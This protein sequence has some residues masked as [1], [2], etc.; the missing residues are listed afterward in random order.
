MPEHD[1]PPPA[2]RKT[3]RV[4]NKFVPPP[5]D[6]TSHDDPLE[7]FPLND[8]AVPA[9]N[10][11]KPHC[12]NTALENMEIGIDLLPTEI[13][14]DYR[15]AKALAPRL[16]EH[17]TT[18]LK[19]LMR[20]DWDPWAAAT[21]ICRHW[22]FRREIFG[23]D[24]W[25][26]PLNDLSGKGAL[27]DAEIHL[28]RRG[29]VALATNNKGRQTMILNSGRLS[30]G[31]TP[32]DFSIRSR[33]FM[34]LVVV[35]STDVSR[36]EGFDV[37]LCAS[38]AGIRPSPSNARNLQVAITTSI[39]RVRH[40][41]TVHDPRDAG[42]MLVRLCFALLRRTVKRWTGTFP[43]AVSG[44]TREA[45]CSRMKQI[46]MEPDCIPEEYGG[47]WSYQQSCD[48]IE[49]QIQHDKG[50]GKGD[51]MPPPIATTTTSYAERSALQLPT[52][53]TA[54]V[55]A[56]IS[57]THPETTPYGT[58]SLVLRTCMELGQ[59]DPKA[60]RDRSFYQKRNREYSRRNYN[61]QKE[62]NDALQTK[63]NLALQER[64]V[65]RDEQL[66]LESL[67]EQAKAIVAATST[68]G[69]L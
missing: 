58:T 38:I 56:P 14:A 41:C 57:S 67:L 15:I 54:S 44:D 52:A 69:T 29:V 37:L 8:V 43:E 9:E 16:V 20:E 55:A 5:T 32:P 51:W 33:C 23:D 65:L 63:Y 31:Q 2:E 1:G 30:T 68:M 59:S 48:I 12:P 4:P 7:S 39:C 24:R 61:R 13:S 66:R 40:I 60:K 11:T 35:W 6:A 49:A 3:T 19:F 17:E 53:T 47:T 46:G 26:L 22:S 27:R 62:R 50:A 45:L 34:Y 25:L 10:S 36:Q 42:R 28:L 18:P 21:R 64:E